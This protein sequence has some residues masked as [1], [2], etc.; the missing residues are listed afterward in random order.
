LTHIITHHRAKDAS[1]SSDNDRL[2]RLTVPPMNCIAWPASFFDDPTK[3]SQR[4]H[5]TVGAGSGATWIGTNFRKIDSVSVNDHKPS[6]PL[7]PGDVIVFMGRPNPSRGPSAISPKHIAI[8]T[9]RKREISML[10]WDRDTQQQ[11][12]THLQTDAPGAALGLSGAER[13]VV[14]DR[15]LRCLSLH[16]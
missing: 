9:G 10:W 11:M 1:S 7:E 3:P 15:R 12:K 4:F 8:A 13:G 2:K 16:W 5:V 6:V 14:F